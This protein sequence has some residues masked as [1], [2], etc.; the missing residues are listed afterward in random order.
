MTNAKPT[1]LVQIDAQGKRFAVAT[2]G[3]GDCLRELLR[4]NV[5]FHRCVLSQDYKESRKSGS[6]YW[7]LIA[8]YLL[9]H[10]CTDS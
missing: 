4:G 10:S 6:K 3:L 7:Q 5:I 1:G 8:T 2:R 9:N